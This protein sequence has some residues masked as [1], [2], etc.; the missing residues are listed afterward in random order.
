[1][2]CPFLTLIDC[3]RSGSGGDEVGLPAEEGGDLEDVADL[4]CG[5]RLFGGVDV[6]E[7]GDVKFFFHS[8][9]DPKPFFEAGAAERGVG[10]AVG[11]IVAR[12]VDE[13]DAA[14]PLENLDELLRCRQS[15]IEAFDDAGAG[16]HS[17]RVAGAN[18]KIFY[19]YVVHS[20]Y[21]DLSEEFSSMEPKNGGKIRHWSTARGAG[22]RGILLPGGRRRQKPPG[23]RRCV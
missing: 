16:H 1:M 11:L 12:L 3:S 23:K 21:D 8:L 20:F 22:S 5:G 14:D 18:E 17:E 10:G 15:V 19:W 13:V 6:G 9:Q 7:D 4:S 2:N